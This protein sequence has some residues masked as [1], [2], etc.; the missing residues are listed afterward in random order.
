MGPY[1]QSH[2]RLQCGSG[3]GLVGGLSHAQK[4]PDDTGSVAEKSL[5]SHDERIKRHIHTL[6]HLADA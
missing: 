3:E 5:F 4:G 1:I 2:H 6:P